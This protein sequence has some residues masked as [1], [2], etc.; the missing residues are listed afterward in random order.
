MDRQVSAPVV[1]DRLTPVQLESS[2]ETSIELFHQNEPSENVTLG[3]NL[4]SYADI[5]QQVSQLDS[6]TK[7]ALIRHLIPQLETEQIST[8]LEVGQQE[9]GERQRRLAAV[10]ESRQTR[11][12]LKK[13]YTYQDR[14]L[15]EP[16]QYYVYLRRR[17]PKLD[18]YIG[19]LFYIPEGCLLSYFPDEEGRLL[20]NPPHNVFRLQ[21]SKNPS[22]IQVVRLIGLEPPPP[23]YT[24]TKQ[25]NDTPE[26]HLRVEY[27]DPVTYQPLSEELYSFPF[28]MYEGGKLDRYR[29][30]VSVV[31]V[32][33]A[34]ELSAT[35]LPIEGQPFTDKSVDRPPAASPAV[36]PRPQA[37]SA[38]ADVSFEAPGPITAK[39]SR[40]VIELS[41]T[42]SSTFYLVNRSDAPSVLERMRLWVTWSEKAMPQSRWEIVQQGS[43]YTLRN[44]SFKRKILSFSPE[45]ASITLENSLPV[46]MK[47]FQDLGLVVSQSQN[48]RQYNSAQIKLAHSLFVDMSLPQKEAVVVLKKLLGVKCSKTSPHK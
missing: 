31:D 5:L 1:N 44:A 37:T 16:T 9:V 22:N 14:G 25:Q 45:Q 47:W 32:A 18:R 34:G 43:V 36:D 33:E 12:L 46:L 48:Q 40:R 24:F 29:W 30:D 10:L 20:F 38:I 15:S 13:D 35:A 23:S 11:L 17:K 26:I 8:L 39:P 27:L 28:C 19:T 21:D 7:A 2:I 41:N 6:Q 4:A 42:A 3:G